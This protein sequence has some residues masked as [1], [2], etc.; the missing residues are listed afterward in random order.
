MSTIN[1]IK[2]D[3]KHFENLKFSNEEILEVILQ[4][5]KDATED[6]TII[7]AFDQ[8]GYILTLHYGKIVKLNKEV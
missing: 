1:A 2:E 8:S 3:I 6:E 7:N 4:N 5:W